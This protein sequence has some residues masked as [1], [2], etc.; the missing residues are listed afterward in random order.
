MKRSKEREDG[1]VLLLAIKKPYSKLIM[2][3]EKRFELRKR[4]PKTACK[5]ALIY[6]THPTKAIVGYFEISKIHFDSVE[7]IWEKTKDASYLTRD[8]FEE[9]Y[10][11]RDYGVAFGIKKS[12]KLNAPL[13]LTEIGINHA[14]QDFMYIRHRDLKELI[15][16]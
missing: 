2:H 3:G 12:V 1:N 4:P 13:T 8:E 15:R 6:E 14:P 9:Y 5:F 7:K 10:R 16:I 11:N